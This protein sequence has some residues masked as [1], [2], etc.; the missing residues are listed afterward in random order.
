MISDPYDLNKMSDAELLKIVNGKLPF[1]PSAKST[2]TA[3]DI[4]AEAQI[5]LHNRQKKD[6]T[7]VKRMTFW[8]LILTAFIAILTAVLAYP[9]LKKY[10][11]KTDNHNLPA[12]QSLPDSKSPVNKKSI[13]K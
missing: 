8:I 13:E 9:E 1:V 12:I 5:I 2:T 10:L 11:S 4:I 7:T 3:S 6:N